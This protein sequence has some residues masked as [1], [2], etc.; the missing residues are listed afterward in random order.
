MNKENFK[1]LLLA[2]L[3]FISVYFVKDFW[4]TALHSSSKRYDEDIIENIERSYKLED[5][6]IPQK[7]I[8][9]FDEDDETVIYSD[10]KC[11][12]W[13]SGKAAL[14][15]VFDKKDIDKYVLDSVR[16]DEL[17]DNRSVNFQFSQEM[18]TN[19][20]GK[21]LGI[22][23]PKE[24]NQKMKTV[25]NIKFS[26][27]DNSFLILENDKD[28]LIIETESYKL[29][30]L[31]SMVSEIRNS[32]Y[33]KFYKS[34]EIL[35]VKGNVYIPVKSQNSIPTV[36]INTKYKFDREINLDDTIAELF[37]YKKIEYIKK[38]EE[39]NGSSIYI[40]GENILKIYRDGRLEYIG[41]MEENNEVDLYSSLKKY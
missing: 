30:G 28:K 41:G 32:N 23:I 26:I 38:L 5:V 35:G 31:K 14:K 12:A 7:T 25:S 19:M 27:G 4:D 8:V 34:E 16:H 40:D 39:S 18:Y 37:F 33:T 2:F 29:K 36:H 9:S 10:N 1:T 24:I 17:S 20:I 11:D 22:E 13:G 21:I 6:I 3:V 15:D